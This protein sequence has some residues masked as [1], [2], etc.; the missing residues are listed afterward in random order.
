MVAQAFNL[1]TWEEEAGGSLVLDLWDLWGL[2]GLQ[3]KFQDSQKPYLHNN[4]MR[5]KTEGEGVRVTQSVDY[6][7]FLK[8]GKIP[9]HL[10]L[11]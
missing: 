3:S 4:K 1:S 11:L 6:F 5:T 8:G 7:L 9:G 2:P 10:I